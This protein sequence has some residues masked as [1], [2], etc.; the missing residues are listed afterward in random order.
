MKRYIN[1]FAY[2]IKAVCC[3]HKLDDFSKLLELVVQRVI[4]GYFVPF[5]LS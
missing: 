2:K 1:T 3:I 5:L 4:P